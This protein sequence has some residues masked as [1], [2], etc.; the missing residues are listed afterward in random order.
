MVRHDVEL[1]HPPL[2]SPGLHDA[3]SDATLVA[4]A[5]LDLHAFTA[6]YER[7]ADSV[8]R[9][10]YHR[11]GTWSEAEDA[12]QQIFLNAYVAL[13]RFQDREGSFRSWLF[14]LAH[15]EIANRQR[16]RRRHPTVPL[17]EANTL[18][19]QGPT[20]EDYAITTDRQERVHRL[21]AQLTDD[22]RRVL[23]LRFAGLT[24][25]EIGSVLG[26][27]PGAIRGVQ[28]R[29]VAHLRHLLGIPAVTTGTAGGGRDA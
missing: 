18:Y 5:Q 1:Q 11:L 21:L 3:A 26:R 8:L 28:A 6:L 17:T 13:G 7:Y 9:Y 24:D 19:D 25:M 4:N 22:Q 12:A 20:P 14:T 16:G 15:H 2:A 27:R 23:E 29:G 10:C